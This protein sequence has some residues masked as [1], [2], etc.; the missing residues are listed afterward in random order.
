MEIQSLWLSLVDSEWGAGLGQ[1]A[2]YWV[3][4]QKGTIEGILFYFSHWKGIQ[5]GMPGSAWFISSEEGP[6]AVLFQ[7][8]RHHAKANV[9]SESISE[10]YGI[11]STL[12]LESYSDFDSLYCHFYVDKWKRDTVLK[13]ERQLKDNAEFK[14]SIRRHSRL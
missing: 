8:S 11:E 3:F 13:N 1:R 5:E 12:T 2:V 14:K 6:F 10:I 9:I 7:I 4:P